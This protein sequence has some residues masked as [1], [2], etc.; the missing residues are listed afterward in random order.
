MNAL[1]TYPGHYMIMWGQLIVT[2]DVD[3]YLQTHP[4]ITLPF[5][6]R[7]KREQGV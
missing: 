1:C 7:K 4:Q 3:A 5:S 6:C 2:K